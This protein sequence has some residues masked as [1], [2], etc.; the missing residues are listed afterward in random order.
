MGAHRLLEKKMVLDSEASGDVSALEVEELWNLGKSLSVD[1]MKASPSLEEVIKNRILEQRDSIV[2]SRN[3]IVGFVVSIALLAIL[4][5]V[6][7]VKNISLAHENLRLEAKI[8]ERVADFEKAKTE[9]EE[10]AMVADRERNKT[11]SLNLDLQRQTERSNSLAKKA[12]AAKQ[13]K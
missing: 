1:M 7:I 12:I 6:Y 8:R 3:L 11:D 2:S 13:A 4:L 9:A 5:G 10:A